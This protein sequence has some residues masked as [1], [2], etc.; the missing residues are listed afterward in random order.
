[1]SKTLHDCEIRYSDIENQALSLVKVVSHFRA[2]ILPSH[3]IAYVPTSPIKISLN[4]KLREGK[5]E[6][7]LVKIQEYDIDIN[8]IKEI[9]GQGLCKLLT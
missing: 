4:K 6:N 3:A 2:Y 9:K 7:W 5:W 1:M 8:P